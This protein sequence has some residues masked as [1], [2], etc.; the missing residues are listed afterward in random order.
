MIPLVKKQYHRYVT[1]AQIALTSASGIQAQHLHFR[2][3]CMY[4]PTVAVGGHQPLM[5]DQ[6]CA[7]YNHY[8]VIGSAIAVRA[9]AVG[10]GEPFGAGLPVVVA[11]G[12]VDDAATPTDREYIMEQGRHA[13]GEVIAGGDAIVGKPT[14]IRKRYSA[15]KWMLDVLADSNTG[16]AGFDPSEEQFYDLACWLPTSAGLA[17]DVSITMYFEVTIDYVALWSEVKDIAMS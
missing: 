10:I 9:H 13:L 2:A 4:D 14:T 16:A 3:N 1:H 15:R 11:V 17:V 7:M 8:N 12:V 6:M 5:F